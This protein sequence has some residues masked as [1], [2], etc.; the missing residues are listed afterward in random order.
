MAK[1]KEFE[2][3]VSVAALD[4][5]MKEHP[6]AYKEIDMDGLK[7]LV[8][9]FVGVTEFAEIV[10]LVIDGS[11]EVDEDT[12]EETYMPFFTEFLTDMQ[13]I[14]K[15]TNITLPQAYTKRYDV[16]SA[17][18]ANGVMG[19]IKEGIMWDQQFALNEAIY[20]GIEYRKDQAKRDACQAIVFMGQR[21]RALGL[22]ARDFLNKLEG[23]VDALDDEEAVKSFI[24]S[25]K[26]AAGGNET[27][28]AEYIDGDRVVPMP[29]LK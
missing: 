8:K 1:K 18:E 25:I 29:G 20:R 4:N 5:Y 13:I 6:V 7:I 28:E 12:G 3:T 16:I 27:D 26:E 2:S 15:Y 24:E 11:F 14:E 21:M 10:S 23:L 17:L 19:S 9:P 22:S